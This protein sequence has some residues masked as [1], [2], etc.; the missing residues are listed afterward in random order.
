MTPKGA[1]M[2]KLSWGHINVNV[3]D[4]EGSIEF[5]ELLGFTLVMPGIPYLNLN[6]TEAETLN[7]EAAV[8]L[9]MPFETKGRACIMELNGGFPKLDLTEWVA[10][11]EMIADPL[12]NQDTGIVRMCLASRDLQ[13]D[14]EELLA[15]G[16][17]FF[18]EPKLTE[19]GKADI[20]I[21]LD[22]D[23]AMI[24]IIQLHL[25]KWA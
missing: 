11:E 14:Y 22:P 10:T 13:K 8:A 21:C 20:A 9:D 25:E 4:L 5:Y 19:D 12:L 2:A 24:E 3:T 16:V 1:F 17:R 23:G 18:S 15:E 7:P 6:Q